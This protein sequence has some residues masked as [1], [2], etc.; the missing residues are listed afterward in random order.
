L[1]DAGLGV[2]GRNP[3][4]IRDLFIRCQKVEE[5][6]RRQASAFAA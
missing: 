1:R 6:S 4:F 3:I 5:H 2:A